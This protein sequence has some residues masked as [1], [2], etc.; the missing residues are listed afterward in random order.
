MPMRLR[1]HRKT[2]CVNIV[3]HNFSKQIP[4]FQFGVYLFK[5]YHH[6]IYTLP[7]VDVGI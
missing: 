7:F 6:V 4:I 3:L 1:Y 2:I 5:C